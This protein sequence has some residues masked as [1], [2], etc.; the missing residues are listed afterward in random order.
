[1]V[2]DEA[3]EDIATSDERP[4]TRAEC[5]GGA[6][7]CPWIACRHHLALD[8]DPKNGAIKVN[9]PDREPW[10]IAETC[11]LDVADRGETEARDIGTMLN[12]TSSR[13][14]QILIIGMR[15]LRRQPRL[16]R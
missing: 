7:P 13:I 9:H 5:V 8:I 11:S 1:M 14:D 3:D 10:E 4:R 15:A 12:V 2:A 6:R 16:R